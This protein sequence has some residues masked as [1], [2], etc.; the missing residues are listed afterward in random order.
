VKHEAPRREVRL[1][2]PFDVDSL[3]QAPNPGYAKSYVSQ[4]L[5]RAKRQKQEYLY[6]GLALSDQ[7]KLMR[8]HDI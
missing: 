6:R 2:T 1:D 8:L 7:A 3:F 5:A 4:A